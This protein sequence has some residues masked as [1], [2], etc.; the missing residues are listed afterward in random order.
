M[1]DLES[2]INNRK[3]LYACLIITYATG[4]GERATISPCCS[5]A[6]V[7]IN[8]YCIFMCGRYAFIPPSIVIL[9]QIDLGAIAPR[10]NIAPSQQIPII[11]QDPETGDLH[12]TYARWGLI[13]FWAKD[14]KIG[15]KMINAR[16][17]TVMQKPAFRAAFK[18]RRCLIPSS[19]F[20]EWDKLG[21]KSQ[22]YFVTMKNTKV[23][24]FAGL[25]EFW[26]EQE[27]GQ[28]IES[29]TIITTAVNALLRRIH[30][31][32]PAIVPPEKYEQWLA[33][34]T[35]PEQLTDLLHPY[36][37]ELMDM[38]PVSDLVNNPR[39][40]VPGCIKQIKLPG[41]E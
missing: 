7:S 1:V 37:A 40:D 36:P 33:K 21:K 2:L 35:P 13:P 6:K 12:S 23:F 30:D 19:G 9:E 32:M 17:E 28:T 14:K 4:A 11:R 24:A 25:W 3:K 41:F 27:T 22:P 26:T 34:D 29:A 20:Y 5:I 18:Y 31:R 16:A 38:Y 15:N 39:N 8:T 10:F